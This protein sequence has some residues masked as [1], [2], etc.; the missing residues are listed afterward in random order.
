MTDPAGVVN[1][2]PATATGYAFPVRPYPGAATVFAGPRDLDPEALADHRFHRHHH[3][4]RDQPHV[5]WGA[6]PRPTSSSA[7]R[8][9]S[10]L[11]VGL[12]VVFIKLK[13]H[14]ARILRYPRHR[15]RIARRHRLRM[16][17]CDDR[18]GRF[19]QRRGQFV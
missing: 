16:A 10:G 9:A 18:G 6:L 14:D 13:D 19:P 3:R 11:A 2:R 8:S 4:R 7:P 12:Q 1:I 5:S 17:V 15:R